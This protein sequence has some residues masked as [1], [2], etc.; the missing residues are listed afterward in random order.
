MRTTSATPIST[1]TTQELLL[2]RLPRLRRGDVVRRRRSNCG[3]RAG[4]VARGLR[5]IRHLVYGRRMLRHSHRA[6]NTGHANQM[7]TG[8][9]RPHGRY[10]SSPTPQAYALGGDR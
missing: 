9:R 7:T 5:A 10:G 4:R 3:A 1:P 6:A 2:A 8:P